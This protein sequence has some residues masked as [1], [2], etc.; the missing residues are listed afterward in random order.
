MATHE[1]DH[2]RHE[3]P[4]PSDVQIHTWLRNLSDAEKQ[5]L[6]AQWWLRKHRDARKKLEEL[7]SAD[8][9][10]AFQAK[11]QAF[12]RQL[13]GHFA[14][15]ERMLLSMLYVYMMNIIPENIRTE[16]KQLVDAALAK[17]PVVRE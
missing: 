9:I 11:I 8:S 16:T 12:C 5:T 3:I 10:D 17:R 7:F 2:G 15:N 4:K 14:E 6:I 1:A 13:G